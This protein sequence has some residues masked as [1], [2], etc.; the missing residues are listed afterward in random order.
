MPTLYFTSYSGDIS[1]VEATEESGAYVVAGGPHAGTYKMDDDLQE[2][3]MPAYFLQWD[4]AREAQIR[5]LDTVIAA[6]EQQLKEH[7]TQDLE[8]LRKTRQNLADRIPRKK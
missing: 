6:S 1:E 2:S 7:A 3:L 5:L 4:A 8:I